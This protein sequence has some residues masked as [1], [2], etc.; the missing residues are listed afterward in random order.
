M[1]NSWNHSDERERIMQQWDHYR[2]LIASG[3]GG[4]L[5]RDWFESELDARDERI[6]YLEDCYLVMSSAIGLC[7]MNAERGDWEKAKLLLVGAVC[8][9]DELERRYCDTGK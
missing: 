6:K 3:F 5:P 1:E 4:A 9:L 2:E 8:N 7:K